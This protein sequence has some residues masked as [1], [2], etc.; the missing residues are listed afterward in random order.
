MGVHGHLV[1]V[2]AV[3]GVVGGELI[4]VAAGRGE[5]GDGLAVVA[6]AERGATLAG[7]AFDDESE[8]PNVTLELVR[9]GYT[10]AQIAKIW[11]GNFLRVFQEVEAVSRTLQKS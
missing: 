1:D 2:F 6:A 11:G 7:A 9:R 5:V 4:A 10:E 8:A 3:L